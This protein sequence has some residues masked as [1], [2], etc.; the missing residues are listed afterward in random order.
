MISAPKPER[1]VIAAFYEIEQEK[2][3][4]DFRKIELFTR[5][6]GSRGTFRERRLKQ[7]LRSASK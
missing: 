2:M 7:Y 3:L 1:D 4:L 5:H 6:P